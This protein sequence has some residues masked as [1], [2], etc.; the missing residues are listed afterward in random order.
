[1]NRRPVLA[2]AIVVLGASAV[3]WAKPADPPQV[4]LCHAK[5]NG[6]FVAITVDDD[7]DLS[8]HQ[9]HDGDL[10][11]APAGG[12]PT[13]T[14]P[15]GTTSSTTTTRPTTTTSVPVITLPTVIVTTTSAPPVTFPATPVE[16]LARIA[17]NAPDAPAA[18]PTP[19]EPRFPG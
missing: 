16:V 2:V 17:V 1:M 6:E 18:T 7:G 3:A 4:T 9:G 13:P 14:G 8:G 12:C 19:A 10:I 5:G 11:P 15:V